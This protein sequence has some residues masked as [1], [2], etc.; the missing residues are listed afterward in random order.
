M[1]R[2]IWYKQKTFIVEQGFEHQG[3]FFSKGALFSC[4]SNDYYRYKKLLSEDEYIPKVKK[5]KELEEKTVKIKTK[6]I[7]KKS[8]KVKVAKPIKKEIK[9]TSIVKKI[10]KKVKKLIK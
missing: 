3:I 10:A 1:L 9:K 5:E 4:Y 8:V 6:P 2:P 7:E